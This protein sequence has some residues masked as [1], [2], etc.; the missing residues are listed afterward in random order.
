[1]SRRQHFSKYYPRYKTFKVRPFNDNTLLS[2]MICA[3]DVLLC[4]QV[5][6]PPDRQVSTKSIKNRN[7]NWRGLVGTV[8]EIEEKR[9]NAQGRSS[10]EVNILRLQFKIDPNI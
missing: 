7:E 4:N 1:M 2:I 3:M 6:T 10:V 5:Y 8:R 9:L